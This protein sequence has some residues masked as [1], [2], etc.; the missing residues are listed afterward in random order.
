MVDPEL[1]AIAGEV[2]GASR[3]GFGGSMPAVAASA[4]T[5]VYGSSTRG[6]WPDE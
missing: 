3:I 4:P 1:V 6:A 5:S 2:R